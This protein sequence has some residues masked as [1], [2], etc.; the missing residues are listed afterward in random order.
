MQC[1]K[2]GFNNIDG[3]KTCAQCGAHLAFGSESE[4]YDHAKNRKV[5]KLPSDRIDDVTEPIERPWEVRVPKRGATSSD[6]AGK[7]QVTRRRVGNSGKIPAIKRPEHESG[8]IPPE[9][10]SS[11]AT[12]P[13]PT[14]GVSQGETQG[15]DAGA[16]RYSAGK[17]VAGA[18]IGGAAAEAASSSKREAPHPRRVTRTNAAALSTVNGEGGSDKRKW[19][20]TGLIILVICCLAIAGFFMMNS[21]SNTK[22]VSFDTDGGSAVESQYIP[23]NGKLDRPA[24]PTKSG[25]VFDGWYL[26]PD[27]SE[28]A[29]F[30]LDV[31]QDITLYAKWKDTSAATSSSSSS[32]ASTSTSTSAN[33]DANTGNGAASG[34]ASSGNATGNTQAAPGASGGNG[35]SA[36]GSS[37]G[38]TGGSAGGNS[39]GG[40]A[41]GGSGGGAATDG[42]TASISAITR[43]GETLSGTVRLHDGYVIPD[44]SQKA[45]SIDELRALGLNDAEMAIARNEPYA[46]LGYSFSNSGLQAYFNARSWYHNSGKKFQLEEGSAG[47]ITAHNLRA[48]EES[49]PSAAKWLN[50]RMS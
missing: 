26:D 5:V 23:E 6:S 29:E 13:I 40:N 8:K 14:I 36:G 16:R 21:G 33:G 17:A 11:A 12:G 28:P 24:N 10:R 22:T 27:Y 49:I 20:I 42:S 37:G 39:G 47:Y 25:Y 7:T 32:S 2:C 35:T 41:G 38:S 18:S 43:T 3:A 48:L 34:N 9:E 45:Y 31:T 44:S 46:R 50:L 1:A 30:P 19:I 4:Y 15:A